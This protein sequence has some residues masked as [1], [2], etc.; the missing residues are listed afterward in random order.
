[1]TDTPITPIAGLALAAGIS[2]GLGAKGTCVTA[3]TPKA[4]GSLSPIER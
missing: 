3:D 4:K 1:M 2:A